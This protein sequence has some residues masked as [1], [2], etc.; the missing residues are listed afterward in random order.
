MACM[1]TLSAYIHLSSALYLVRV[2]D[3]FDT[4]CLAFSWGARTPVRYVEFLAFF[5]DE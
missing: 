5:H 2:R 4:F 3:E 1:Y